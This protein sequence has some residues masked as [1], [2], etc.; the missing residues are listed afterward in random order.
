MASHPRAS[1]GALLLPPNTHR[2]RGVQQPSP[3]HQRGPGFPAGSCSPSNTRGGLRASLEAAAPPSATSPAPTPAAGRS[4]ETGAGSSGRREAPGHTWDRPLAYSKLRPNITPKACHSCCTVHACVCEHVR[5]CVSVCAHD[6]M[7]VC[8]SA[9]GWCVCMHRYVCSHMTLEPSVHLN[10]CI[11]VCMCWLVAQA[12]RCQCVHTSGLGG[13]HP[14]PK[15]TGCPH[16]HQNTLKNVA[17]CSNESYWA[18]TMYRNG[19]QDSNIPAL[20]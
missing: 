6:S 15:H 1:S 18:P 13:P 16:W 2:W 17:S 9:R 12:C 14:A 11:Q 7:G 19:T 5:I 3:T 8:D 20:R 10:T 4:L